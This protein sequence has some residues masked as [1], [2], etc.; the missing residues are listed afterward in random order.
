[1]KQKYYV[2]TVINEERWIECQKMAFS[3]DE[4]KHLYKEMKRMFIDPNVMCGWHIEAMEFDNSKSEG[5][6][7]NAWMK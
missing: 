4:A 7:F 2:I 5:R 3:A 6:P 1:M